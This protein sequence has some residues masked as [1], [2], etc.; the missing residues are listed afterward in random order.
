MWVRPSIAAAL[1]ML[2]TLPCLAQA[3]PARPEQVLRE[4]V[5]GLPRGEQQEIQ[6]LT[7]SILPGQA[8]AFHTHRFPVTV[9]V[10]EGA[11]T[12]EME[13]RSTVTIIAGQAMVEPPNVRMTGFNRSAGTTRVVIF[14]VAEPGTPFLDLIH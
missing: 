9:F 11:F 8:T 14:Y 5:Q 6:V 10:L 7:A 12:L 13:G 1:A 4:V 2:A 3:P